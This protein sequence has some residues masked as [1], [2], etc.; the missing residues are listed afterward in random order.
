MNY[1]EQINSTIKD[2]KRV[3]KI[4]RKPNQEEYLA[5]TKVTAIGIVIIGI[6]GFIIVIIGQL[7]GL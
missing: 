6:V 4:S 3:L 5:F 2:C 7:I 1:R